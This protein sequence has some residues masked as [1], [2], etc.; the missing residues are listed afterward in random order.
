MKLNPCRHHGMD[1]RN[2]TGVG[3]ELIMKKSRFALVQI[4]ALHTS[5]CFCRSTK[6]LV[7]DLKGK[8][9][10]MVHRDTNGIRV[11][12]VC[13]ESV[14]RD[15]GLC[16]DPTTETK[17]G[18]AGSDV[19]RGVRRRGGGGDLRVEQ[20]SSENTEKQVSRRKRKQQYIYIYIRTNQ[21][22]SRKQKKGEKYRKHRH[23]EL[24]KQNI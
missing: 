2:S 8:T 21:Q 1:A 19:C 23:E 13:P 22:R 5:S 17:I 16:S 12:S 14:H 9:D 18:E 7:Q 3:L 11:L 24:M 4:P 20:V 6:H 15:L 10:H